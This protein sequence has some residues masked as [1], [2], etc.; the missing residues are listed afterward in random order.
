MADLNDNLVVSDQ[1]IA[2]KK[3]IIEQFK[4]TVKGKKPDTLKANI[5]HSGKEG[6]W[7]EL[8]M[9]LKLNRSNSPDL[10]GFEMKNNTSGKTTFG[11]WSAD[12]YIYKDNAYNIARDDFIALFGKSN[13]KKNGRFSW[14]GEPFPK[15]GDFNNF[16]QKLN[17]DEDGNIVALYSFSNDRRADKAVI[18]PP[19]FQQEDLVL[20][21]WEA[22]TLQTKLENKFNQNGWFKCIKNSNGVYVSI[23]FGAPINYENWIELVRRG[24]VFLDSGMYQGNK[25][26]YSNWR[27][28]NK[29]WESLVVSA[30]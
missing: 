15:I 26:P 12:Y 8:A 11:D 17:V 29:L 13:L 1:A 6:H 5:K 22:V 24:I 21:R 19:R 10:L 7:L 4:A 23:V 30:H 14:S 18:L 27:A 3:I 2:N 20:A 16:G 25:R 28:D 9:G